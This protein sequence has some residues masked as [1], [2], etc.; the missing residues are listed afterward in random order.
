[1]KDNIRIRLTPKGL[2]LG[3]AVEA[4]IMSKPPTDEEMERFHQFWEQ[5]KKHLIPMI[6]KEMKEAEADEA[7]VSGMD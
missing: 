4:G 7:P 2:A 6:L 3:L 1:M 5:A